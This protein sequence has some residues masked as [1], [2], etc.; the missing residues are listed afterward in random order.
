MPKYT[1]SPV[2]ASPPLPN[3]WE[4]QESKRRTTHSEIERKRRHKIDAEL[5]VLKALVPAMQVRDE[6]EKL[7]ILKGA[8]EYIKQVQALL[9][10]Y[11]QKDPQLIPIVSPFLPNT[12]KSTIMTLLPNYRPPAGMASSKHFSA[13]AAPKPRHQ[14]MRVSS[15]LS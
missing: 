9:T 12:S 4:T 6:S 8:A 11:Q 5:Q 14:H 1:K 13:P 15:L 10:E 7:N 3:R 2:K